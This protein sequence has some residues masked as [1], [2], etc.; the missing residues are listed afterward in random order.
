LEQSQVFANPF[1]VAAA[2]GIPRPR[3]RKSMKK[4]KLVIFLICFTPFFE[5]INLLFSSDLERV[6]T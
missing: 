3:R 2:A 4:T 6:L 5:T 1:D